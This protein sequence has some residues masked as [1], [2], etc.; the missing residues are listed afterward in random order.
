MAKKKLGRREFLKLTAAAAAA[1][2]LSHF[3]F[4]N[5][6]G[7]NVALADECEEGLTEDSDE[8]EGGTTEDS[9]VCEGGPTEDS[10]ECEEGLTEDSDECEGGPTE[11]SDD[12]EEGPTEDSDDCNQNSVDHCIPESNNGG[13]PDLCDPDPGTLPADMCPD[14]SPQGDGDICDPGAEADVCVPGT[15]PDQC[16]PGQ[17]D[18]DVCIGDAGDGDQCTPP[19]DPDICDPPPSGSEPDTDCNSG[20]YEDRCISESGADICHNTFGDAEDP[21]FCDPAAE[22]EPDS[23][24]CEPDAG[25]V[26][27]CVA[28]AEL[29]VC[30][31]NVGDGD[32]CVPQDDADVCSPTWDPDQSPTPVTV[33]SLEAGPASKAWPA[34]GGLVAVVGAAALWLRRH[35]GD[36]ESDPD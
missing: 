13:D 33:T 29:D 28:G 36:A 18:P 27:V 17:G 22:P 19:A 31:D 21:D 20:D 3:Q 4:L 16:A 15:D 35:L 23:D 34:L 7:P 11:D 1:A 10:D 32:I 24:V 2:G 8:C 9:D 6:G 30:P 5:I 12:C 26:D 25:E 14:D